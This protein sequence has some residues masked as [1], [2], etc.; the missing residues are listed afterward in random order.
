MADWSGTGRDERNRGPADPLVTWAFATF[1]AAT[2]VVALVVVAHVTG[3]LGDLLGGL[4]T[5]VGLALFVVLWATTWWTNR[6][7]LA[8]VGLRVGEQPPTRALVFGGLLWGGANGVLF[9]W[10]V[11]LLAVLPTFGL[12]VVP[13]VIIA[14]AGTVLAT[15]VGA[16]VGGL[17]AV[18]DAALLRLAGSFDQGG[19]AA[20]ERL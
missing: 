16:L 13:L 3:P 6:R 14:T 15:V 17:F 20:P 7:W 19:T 5:L 18:L 2:L 4:D 1:H 12:L 8:A 10:G 11:Y 9:F